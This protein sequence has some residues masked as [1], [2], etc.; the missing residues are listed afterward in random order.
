M[1]SDPAIVA[2]KSMDELC[3]GDPQQTMENIAKFLAIFSRLALRRMARRLAHNPHE[4]KA[5]IE[6][7]RKPKR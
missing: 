4:V 7:D 1:P 2:R 6:D 5:L 3:A